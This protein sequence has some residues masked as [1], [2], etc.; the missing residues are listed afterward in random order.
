MYKFQCSTELMKNQKAAQVMSA[1]SLFDVLQ[2]S[3]GHALFFSIGDDNVFYLSAEQDDVKTGW[4]PINLTAELGALYPGKTVTAKTFAASQSPAD[5]SVTV[6]QV[7][8]VAEDDADYLY[9]L[10]GLSDAPEAAWMQSPSGRQWLAR[11]YDDAAHPVKNLDIAYVNITPGQDPTQAPYMIAGVRDAATSFI[12]N[13]VVSLSATPPGQVWTVYQ[14][15]ENY[16]QL[17]GMQIGKAAGA[18]FSGLYELYNLSGNSGLTF[19]P[20]QSLFGPP[21]VTKLTPP[22]GASSIA[23]LPAGGGNTDLYVAGEGGVYYYPAAAQSNFATGTEVVNSPLVAGV[24]FLEAHL[25][26]AEVVLWG[27]NNQG[28]VFYT[29]CPQGQQSDASA[30]SSPVPVEQDASQMASLL[31]RQTQSNELYVH[32]SAQGLVRLT[33]DPV[34]T[35]W[36]TQS[37][38]L[39]ALGVDDVVEFYTFTTHVNVVDESKLLVP[40][41]SFAVTATSPCTVYLDD[42]YVTLSDTTPL[43]AQSD[44]TGTLTL[45]QQTQ[46]LG[47]VCYNLVQ[48]DGTLLNVNPMDGIMSQLSGV[49]AGADLTSVQVTDEQ[50]NSTPL[51]PST[52]TPSQAD[53]AAKSVAQFVQISNGLPQDGSLQKA[54]TPLRRA[55]DSLDAAADAVWGVSFAGG[56]VRYFEGAEQMPGMGLSLT[57]GRLAL[58]AP[59][60]SGDIGDAIEALAGDIFRWIEHALEDVLNFVVHVA[61]GVAHFFV[62]IGEQWYH[63]LLRCIDDVAHGIQFVLN[64]IGAAFEKLVQWLGFIFNWGDILRTHRVLKNIFLRYAESCVASIPTWEGDLNSFFV[65]L[66]DKLNAWAKLPP[67]SQG[68]VSGASAASTPKPG[69]GS[70][71]AHWGVQQTKSNMTGSSTDFVPGVPGGSELEGLL[72]ALWGTIEQEEQNLKAAFD[73]LHEEV[74]KKIT[75]IPAGEL[76]ERIITIFLDL[77]ISTAQDI[78]V[79]LLKILELFLQG[80][81]DALDAPL[82]IPVISWLYKLI[83]GDQLSFLDLAC[84]MVAIPAT[85]IYKLA[86]ETVPFPDDSTTDALINAPDFATIRQILGGGG[87][88][89]AATREAAGNGAPAGEAAAAVPASTVVPIVFDISAYFATLGLIPLTAWKAISPNSKAASLLYFLVY[90][91]YVSPNIQIYN[92]QTWDV[93]WD[94]VNTGVSVVKALGDIALC[95]FNKD[96]PDQSK[97]LEWWSRASPYA[98]FSINVLWE[99][100]AVAGVVRDHSGR[101]V[102]NFLGNT[103][104]NLSGIVSPW[105]AKNDIF[106]AAML[107]C[108][109][110]YGEME[111]VTGLTAGDA[112]PPSLPA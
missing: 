15:A 91:P 1:Q 103:A 74:I 96:E 18:M 5:G 111:L 31:N 32:T 88:Q 48:G 12:Q 73:N 45:V 3:A 55:A 6:A 40:N 83:S 10:T 110:V 22:A 8:H 85:I 112:P 14:T 68:T 72:G 29:R 106:F 99:V 25:S 82:H 4:T 26:G 105:A 7:V 63:F 58:A 27:R 46:T 44:A 86:E 38:L 35:Q 19:T 33:Q 69:Q 43:Q 36:R 21:P 66:Q 79:S 24:Q 49:Q 67:V 34:T 65:G 102:V 64:K 11:P 54:G 62:Q 2:T 81:L 70:P 80:A 59:G 53:S 57:G 77:V 76:V 20:L 100:P 39:P 78:L 94:E 107:I 9:L 52:V 95:N 97:I 16:S 60:P 108:M 75:T 93:K 23:T 101:G 71:Q 98:E 90:L 13:Y 89:P 92:A 47:A 109:G 104:F 42:H 61:E 87:A 37:I 51:L 56:D 28:Q 30:W 84:L 17:L 50:G 41:Q